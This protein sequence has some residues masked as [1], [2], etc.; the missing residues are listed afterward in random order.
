MSTHVVL[1]DGYKLTS[2]HARPASLWTTSHTSSKCTTTE[3][4]DVK[5]GELQ[6]CHSKHTVSTSGS[7]VTPKAPMGG[8]HAATLPRALLLS[9]SHLFSPSLE[10]GG[11][12]STAGRRGGGDC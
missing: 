1:R 5:Q 9:F 7:A 10:G 11:S 4:C 12:N 2:S 6:V 8:Y 3:V